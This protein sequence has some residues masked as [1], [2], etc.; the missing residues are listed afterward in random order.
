VTWPPSMFIFSN[1]VKPSC[2]SEPPESCVSTMRGLIGLPQ[3]AT[4]TSFSIFTWPVSV[5]TAISTPAPATI[6]NGV[7]FGVM[8]V[9]GC[10][11]T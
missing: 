1:M 8:P 4:L 9:P 6:Q 5:S 7:A 10:G 11:G 2:M 3:S